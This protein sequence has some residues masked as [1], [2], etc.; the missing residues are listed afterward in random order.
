MIAEP[1]FADAAGSRWTVDVD[2]L[3][4]RVWDEL[5][6]GFAD[7]SYDQT[8]SWVDAR[9]GAQRSSHLVLRRDGRPVAAACAVLF[10]WPG[11]RRG[12]AYVKWAPLCR[13]RDEPSAVDAYRR[14]VDALVAEYCTRRGLYLTVLPRVSPEDHEAHGRVLRER[15][16]VVRRPMLDPN[17]Y[18]VDVTLD[19]VARLASI[20]QKWRYNLRRALASGIEC[21]LA[22]FE[23]GLATFTTLHGR[24]R[25]RKRYAAAEALHALPALAANLPERMRPRI[26][27]A[28]R[29]G[30]PV[31]G[32]VVAVCGDT[33][34]YV[35]GA[36]DDAALDLKAGYALQWWIVEWLSTLPIRWYDLGGEALD[37][38]LRQF[39]KGLVGKRGVIVAASGE[40]DRWTGVGA[41]LA[42]DS[43]Y[44]LRDVG[45]ALRL[46]RLRHANG[47]ATDA[48]A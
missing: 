14:C 18:L 8:A 19:P 2:T 44:R 38:G 7:A 39:K 37:A 16:F 41:R 45:R 42:A 21:R 5:V 43:I 34:Y 25:A 35:F 15:G 22:D 13:P 27:L 9:W 33:A 30:T 12:I 24:M 32:A 17:R 48:P 11:I 4:P 40:Y 1:S 23:P 31:A 47:G 29:A 6:A 26:V 20:A 3:A 36:T 10:R 28:F 46:L